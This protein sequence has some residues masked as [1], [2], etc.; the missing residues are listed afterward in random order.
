MPRPHQAGGT[1]RHHR[2]IKLPLADPSEVKQGRSATR[3]RRTRHAS[4]PVVTED[5]QP[6]RKPC[7]VPAAGAS[8][9]MELEELLNI[10]SLEESIFDSPQSVPH[11]TIGGSSSSFPSRCQKLLANVPDYMFALTLQ[12]PDVPSF[13]EFPD[14]SSEEKLVEG[15][16]SSL[17]ELLDTTS[18]EESI[19]AN[20]RTVPHNTIDG[21]L[22]TFPSRFGKLVTGAAES[23]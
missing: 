17:E 2:Q 8:E 16:V 14:N 4:S 5:L 22:R 23:T 9:S 11:K 7:E 21:L 19:T 15:A 6:P 20:P 1:R 10:A 12:E 18:S 3:P 13:D